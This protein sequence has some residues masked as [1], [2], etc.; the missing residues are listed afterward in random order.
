[1]LLLG[2]TLFFFCSPTTMFFSPESFS[3]M[4][5]D[6]TSKL[7]KR[8]EQNSQTEPTPNNATMKGWMVSGQETVFC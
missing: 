8:K 6:W 4:A 5:G 1:M 7:A 3:H 2:E